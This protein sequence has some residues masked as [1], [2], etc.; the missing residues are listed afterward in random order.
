MK[1]GRLA[2]FLNHLITMETVKY[3]DKRTVRLNNNS[4][5]ERFI[6]IGIEL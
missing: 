4:D 6:Y 5:R 1:T 2:Y 3:G